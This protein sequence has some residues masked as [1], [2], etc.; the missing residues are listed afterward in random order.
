M[1]AKL[2]RALAALALLVPGSVLRAQE[3]TVLSGV[4][5]TAADGLA[6]PG[7]TVAIESL[8]LSAVTDSEGRYTLTVTANGHRARA[9][10]V[11]GK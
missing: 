1:N 9:T 7:A 8:G 10:V 3:A 5:T 2:I 4:V 6:V 11:V